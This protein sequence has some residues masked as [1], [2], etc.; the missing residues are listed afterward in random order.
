LLADLAAGGVPAAAPSSVTHSVATAC[1]A[2]V[3]ALGGGSRFRSL[4]N[5][6]VT[7]GIRTR[8]GGKRGPGQPD[9][10]CLPDFKTT[11][12]RAFD[13]AWPFREVHRRCEKPQPLGET[14]RLSIAGTTTLQPGQ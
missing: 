13:H 12:G 5:A 6:V 9:Q 8:H 4:E 7:A 14:N 10:S 3:R 2:R 1:G 11:A